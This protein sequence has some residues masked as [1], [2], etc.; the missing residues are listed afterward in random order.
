VPS[1]LDVT[2]ALETV[3]PRF[4][5]PSSTLFALEAALEEYATPEAASRRYVR[6]QQLGEYVRQR[7][8]GLGIAPLAREPFAAPVLTTFHPP[9]EEPSES[10]VRRCESWGFTIGG[11]SGYLRERRLVQIATMGELSP[12]DCAPLFDRLAQS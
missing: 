10:F 7:L 9:G 1:Y 8:R 12:E 11:A 5:F 4:T 2:A 3:G 6:Y